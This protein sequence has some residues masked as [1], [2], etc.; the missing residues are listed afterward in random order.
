MTSHGEWFHFLNIP[1]WPGYVETGTN[2]THPIRHI[3]DG[4]F[5]KE[6]N[7]LYIKNVLHVPT[8]TKNVVEQGMQV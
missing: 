8:I 7:K 6:G 1:E 5:S 4:P 2:T 3:D